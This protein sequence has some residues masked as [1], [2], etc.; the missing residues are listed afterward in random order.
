MQRGAWHQC[1]DRSQK[2]VEEQLQLGVGVGVILSPRDLT[3][4]RALEYAATY[5]ASG[6]EVLLDHQFYVPDFTNQRLNS[7]P[8]SNYRNAI[9]ALNN[10]TDAD[11]AEIGNQLRI[12][13]QELNASAVIAPAVVY[14]AGRQDIVQL[15]SRLF[16]M[17]REVA[18]QLNLP[19][20]AT[21]VLGR[22]VAAS[23]QTISAALSNATALNA[24][25]WY[26]AFEFA[27]ERIPSSREA[28]RRCFVAGLTLA[29]TGKPVL[30]AYAGPLGLMSFGFG[31]TGVALGHSQN[32]WK[33]T[34]ERWQPPVSQGGGGDAPAR[35]FSTN[36]WGTIIYPDETSQL[37]AALRNQVLTMSPFSNQ[38]SS[39]LPWTRWD[40]GKHLVYHL[41]STF[42]QMSQIGNPRQ[43]MQQAQQRLQSAVQI[44]QAIQ[45]SGVFLADNT[46]AYQDNWRLAIGDVLATNQQDYDYLD[47]LS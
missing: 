27:D 42:S 30:H 18:D 3:R 35:F 9:S 40:A 21:V 43:A 16:N 39:N 22:S 17:A 37:T 15:N 12:D 44:H 1:G 20:Y 45:Q 47:L 24:D 41:A 31:A 28:V 36:L 11:L 38:V 19:V 2:L 34:R 29:C 33:F 7:Y 46:N 10:L 8:I 6:A 13:H 4:A 5:I 25:G 32:L 14:E 23:D 26:F